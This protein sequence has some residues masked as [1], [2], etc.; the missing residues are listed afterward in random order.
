ME[1]ATDLKKTPLYDAHVAHKGRMIPFTGYLLPVQYT[2]IVDEHVAV[3]TAAGLFDVSHMGELTV[4]GP[5][6]LAAVDRLVTNDVR[7]LQDGQ[8]RY[9]QCLNAQGTTLDDLIVY[10]VSAQR[11]LIVCNASNR[12]K[13]VGHFVREVTGA[14]VT[15]ISDDTALIALQGPRAFEILAAAGVDARVAELPAFHFT[16]A[17]IFN[18]PATFS[19]T[20]YTGEDGVEIFLPPGDALRVWNGLIGLGGDYGLKPA[21]L[22][23]RNTL[24]LECKMALYGNDIDETTHP[25]ES[26]LGWTVRLDKGDFIGR[27]ALLAAK[28]AGL[29]RKLVGFEVTE[30]AIA[31]DHWDVLDASGAKVGYV[32]SG[33]PSPT[34]G[35][36]IGLAY[37]PIALGELGTELTLRDPERGRTAKA[38]VVKTPFYKRAK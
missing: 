2:G 13:I 18:V 8:C 20:G 16:D 15:D 10:R 29:T 23:A 21:G 32:T 38:L 25:L 22:G 30:R 12:A 33:S 26:G 5:D 31:R 7:G 28:S 11:V 24:R 1:A 3:R 9:T 34:T 17:T 35:K 19:R 36:N 6:A 4:E 27:D 37:V 14:K